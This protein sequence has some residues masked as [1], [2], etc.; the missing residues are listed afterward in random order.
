MVCDK[1]LISQTTYFDIS[2][3]KASSNTNLFVLIAPEN[4]LNMID[5]QPESLLASGQTP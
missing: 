1:R 3:K 5:V 4:L 2:F